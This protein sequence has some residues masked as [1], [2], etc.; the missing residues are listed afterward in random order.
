MQ[1]CNSRPRWLRRWVPLILASPAYRELS[2]SLAYGEYRD[3]GYV[4]RQVAALARQ[5][6]NSSAVGFGDSVIEAR[7]LQ[8]ASEPLGPGPTP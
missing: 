6:A 8:G 1:I 7:D 4:E 5:L 3:L 2:L